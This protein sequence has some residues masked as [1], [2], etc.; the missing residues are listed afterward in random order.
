MSNVS[1]SRVNYHVKQVENLLEM[2]LSNGSIFSKNT[3]IATDAAE[4]LM[5]M[6]ILTG[7]NEGHL[8]LT[9]SGTKFFELNSVA[10]ELSKINEEYFDSCLDEEHPSFSETDEEDAKARLKNLVRRLSSISATE[11]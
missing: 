11:E 9:E 6:L 2:A 7:A 1:T 5:S 3:A 4:G 10:E 8:F